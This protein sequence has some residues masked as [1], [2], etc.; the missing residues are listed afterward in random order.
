M[1]VTEILAVYMSASSIMLI[2][3]RISSNDN[4]CPELFR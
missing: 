2:S 4:T 3:L 1:L